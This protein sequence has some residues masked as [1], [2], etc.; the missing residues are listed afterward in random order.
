VAKVTYNACKRAWK[1]L[2]GSDLHH[3]GSHVLRRDYDLAACNNNRLCAAWQFGEQQ[4]VIVEDNIPVRGSLEED[5]LRCMEDRQFLRQLWPHIKQLPLGQRKALL[6]N[7]GQA[8]LRQL[9]AMGVA[10]FRDI[11][12]TVGKSASELADIWNH[13]PLSEEEVAAELGLT[14][15]Q[16][17]NRRYAAYRTLAWEMRGQFNRCALRKLWK[18]AIALEAGRPTVFML[19]ARDSHGFS[20]LKLLP[21]ESIASHEDIRARLALSEKQIKEVW[22]E[23]PLGSARIARLLNLKIDEVAEIHNDA[24]SKLRHLMV[25]ILAE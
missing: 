9:P 16:V 6:L 2:S 3:G 5:T 13:L 4:H 22:D 25:K 14:E 19:H 17:R 23:L 11:A 18:T 7:C 24:H 20:L 8:D 12:E 15:Q 21:K 1:N 10:S